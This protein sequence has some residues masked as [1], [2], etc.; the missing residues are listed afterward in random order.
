MQPIPDHLIIAIDGHSSCGKSTFARAIA[1]RLNYRY[2]DSGAMYRAVTLFSIQNHLFKGENPDREKLLRLLPKINISFEYNPN[3]QEN[4][5]VLNGEFVENA[6]R[7][8][9]VARKV[10]II[11]K[12]PEVRSR[13]VEIQRNLGE[14]GGIVMDGR[15]IG[16]VVF[17][18]ADI[19]IFLTASPEIRA[20]RRFKEL[21]EKGI[22][23]GFNEVLENI[24]ERDRIDSTRSVS[25]LRKAPDAILLDNSN[26]TVEQQMEWFEQFLHERFGG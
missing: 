18:N 26:M 23:M 17:S 24:L 14:K 19:K 22:E 12:I 8:P 1:K 13:M 4:E 5:I 21:K 6:I 16:T 7:E 11:S 15:D 10:S 3:R 25:P 2:I 9:E 20:Q